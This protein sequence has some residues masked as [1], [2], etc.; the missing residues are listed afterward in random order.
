MADTVEKLR[1]TMIRRLVRILYSRVSHVTVAFSA[2]EAL[3]GGFSYAI[4]YHALI[5]RVSN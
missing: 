4:Y 2:S 3:Q 1:I 5:S